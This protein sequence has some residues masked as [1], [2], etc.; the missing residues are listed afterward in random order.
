[1]HTSFRKERQ[2]LAAKVA[3]TA[4][5]WRKHLHNPRHLTAAILTISAWCLVTTQQLLQYTTVFLIG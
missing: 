3:C 1:M 4:R 2:L 5:T